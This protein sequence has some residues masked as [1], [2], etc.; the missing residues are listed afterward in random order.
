MED[1]VSCYFCKRTDQPIIGKFMKANQN[2]KGPEG[3]LFFHKDCIEVNTYSFFNP[4]KQKWMNLG[5][6]LQEL[7]QK[8]WFC[9]RCHHIG[10]TIKCIGCSKT[11]HGHLCS[12]LYMIETGDRLF[13]CFECRNKDNYKQSKGKDLLEKQEL[14]LIKRTMPREFLLFSKQSKDLYVPQM[15][16]LVYYFF[17][18][19]ERFISQYNCFFYAGEDAKLKFEYPWKIYT[20]LETPTLCRILKIRYSFPSQNTLYL[21]KRF[22]K[23]SNIVQT[24]QVILNLELMIEDGEGKKTFELEYFPNELP[25]FLIL[26]N[27]YENALF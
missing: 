27:L 9:K 19:H 22:G 17:Q 5:K 3:P 18:G 14:K 25:Q 12:T 26:K 23:S 8:S 16:D 11:Y 2:S 21:C 1:E 7:S 20:Q 10:S 13:Q 4:Q 6:A 15:N 24:P